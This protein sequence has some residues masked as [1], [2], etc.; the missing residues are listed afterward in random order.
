M[1]YLDIMRPSVVLLSG[2]GV[3]VG[4]LLSNVSNINLIILGVFVSMIIS[5][6]GNIHNDIIDYKIDKN[7]KP[8]RP[9]PSGKIKINEARYLA[10]GMFILGILL[11]LFTNIWFIGLVLFNVFFIYFYNKYLKRTIFGH[12]ADSWLPVSTF[13]AGSFLSMS[14]N[15]I[16]LILC[17]MS[18]FA[19]LGREIVKGIEDI[20]GD[21][22]EGAN[23]FAVAF[24]KSFASLFVIVF[25]LMAIL[26]SPFPYTMGFFSIYY[27]YIVLIAD[28]MFGISLFFLP[29]PKKSQKL[30]KIAMFIGIISF[31]IG[32][33]TI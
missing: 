9:I 21:K 10:T 29:F 6:A 28:S 17:F 26:I 2:F 4:A 33:L 1:K 20:R 12:F 31:L 25:I 7:N 14:I 27:L 5:G 11:S 22:K 23:T 19:N 30:M 32:S 15:P 16:V 3:L 24:G 18:Y 8:E 13:L